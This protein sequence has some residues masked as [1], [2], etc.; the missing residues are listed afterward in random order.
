M[1][2]GYLLIGVVLVVASM[3]ALVIYG[4]TAPQAQSIV[5]FVALGIVLSYCIWDG[6][7]DGIAVEGKS[8]TT[9]NEYRQ[10]ILEARGKNLNCR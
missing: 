9:C 6:Y 2:W 7:M 10:A 5:L 4:Y 3:I 1:T 8:I